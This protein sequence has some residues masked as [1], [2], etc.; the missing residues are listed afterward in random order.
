MILIDVNGVVNFM[1]QNGRKTQGHL[2][3]VVTLS[4]NRIGGFKLK[5]W[6]SIRYR[7]IV[8]ISEHITSR[9]HSAGIFKISSS[10]V[11]IAL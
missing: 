2:W 3:G 1:I 8:S 5:I 4:M 10:K 11:D 7:P 9:L 6:T